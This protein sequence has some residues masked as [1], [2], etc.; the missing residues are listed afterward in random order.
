MY[1]YL[2]YLQ[3]LVVKVP[4]KNLYTE[5]VIIKIDGLH[6]LVTPNAAVSYDAAAEAAASLETKKAAISKYES[7]QV[8]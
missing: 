5:P 2:G 7:S 6:L 3:S 1:I 8:G 4:W